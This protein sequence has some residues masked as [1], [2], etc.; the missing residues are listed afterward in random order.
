M[1][2]RDIMTPDPACCTK[3]TSLTDVAALMQEHDCGAIPVV[4]C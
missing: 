4:V 3:D 2:V 1:Q